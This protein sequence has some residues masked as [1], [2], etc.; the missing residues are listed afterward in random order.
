MP[1]LQPFTL[2]CQ[3]AQRL[4]SSGRADLHIHTTFSDGSYTPAEVV[5]LARR[6]G[7]AAI[8][9]TDHDTLAGIRAAQQ[10][11][12]GS[13]LEVVPGVEITAELEGF[14]LHLL[15]YGV[16]LDDEALNTGLSRLE[17]HRIGRFWDMVERLRG[18]GVSLDE[19]E[20]RRQTTQGVLSRRHLAM[21]LVKGRQAGSVREAF[22]RYLGDGN[23]IV[24]PKLR[25]PVREAI[26]M[27]HAAGG[28]ASWAHPSHHCTRD[29]LIQL[30]DWGLHAVEAGYPTFK[31]RWVTQLRAW[32]RELGMLVTA[33][34]D[35]HGAGREIGACSLT[36]DE[37]KTLKHTMKG[38]PTGPASSK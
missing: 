21:M 9:I 2:L 17:Q 4:V 23:S 37:W 29:R 26:E 14:E 24:V 31:N 19:K 18:R 22:Q 32:A 5:S 7:L 36:A 25:L 20:L 33:G 27:V 16:R 1:A 6:S 38:V 8:A 12:D 11:A 30:R 10:A 3:T 34:S 28:I 15:G 35:C 13:S